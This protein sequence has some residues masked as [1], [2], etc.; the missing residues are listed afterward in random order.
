MIRRISLYALLLVTLVSPTLFMGAVCS[1]AIDIPILVTANLPNKNSRGPFVLNLDTALREAGIQ[2]QDGRI[3]SDAPKSITVTHSDKFD[4]RSEE[5]IKSFGSR[6]HSIYIND[7]QVEAQDNTLNTALPAIHVGVTQ[8]PSD[9]TLPPTDQYTK[10]A[11]F[12][13][14]AAS[15]KGALQ[16]PAWESESFQVV[17]DALKTFAIAVEL[18]TTITLKPG[19]PWPKGKAQFKLKFQF[20]FVIKPI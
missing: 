1:R 6:V 12:S 13:G 4:L 14:V 5:Q 17:K 16:A 11:E 8:L 18:K 19:D 7:I 20:A 2:P 9:T 3:P 15:E 10:V